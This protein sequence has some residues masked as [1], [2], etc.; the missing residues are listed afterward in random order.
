MAGSA[1]ASLQALLGGTPVGGAVNV[2]EGPAGL[3]SPCWSLEDEA[4]GSPPRYARPALGQEGP[5]ASSR[6][7]A[8]GMPYTQSLQQQQGGEE[9]RAG[10]SCEAV[11][12]Q[13]AGTT[14]SRGSGRGGALLP[15]AG[16]QG[17]RQLL[18]GLLSITESDLLGSQQLLPGLMLVAETELGWVAQLPLPPGLGAEELRVE[19]A[20]VPPAVVVSGGRAADGARTVFEA[21]WALPEGANPDGARAEVKVGA[22]RAP[23]DW[24]ALSGAGPGGG[25]R[26]AVA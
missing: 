3:P 14:G 10:S 12:S 17:A 11:P 13:A 21:R 7:A 8:A 15:L 1:L 4:A 22:G 26:P 25:C 24:S 20:G 2:R 6:T 9:Q 16:R 23:T 19:L 18:P 5:P